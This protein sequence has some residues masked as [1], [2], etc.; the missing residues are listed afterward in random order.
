MNFQKLNINSNN[1]YYEKCIDLLVQNELVENDA[2]NIDS[3]C[4]NKI[5]KNSGEYNFGNYNPQKIF[6]LCLKNN[7][8]QQDYTRQSHKQENENQLLDYEKQLNNLMNI[9]NN[10][11]LRKRVIEKKEIKNKS[12]PRIHTKYAAD[13]LQ[14]KCKNLVLTYALEF[15]NYQIKKIYDG[16]IGNGIYI[17]KLLDINQEQKQKN[18]LDYINKFKYKTI[19]EI[20]STEISK[21]YKSY[22]PNHNEIII[23]RAL[24]EKNENKRKKFIKLFNLTFLDYIHIFLGNVKSIDYEGFQIF[25]DIKGKFNESNEYI[26]KMKEFLIYLGKKT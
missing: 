25:D 4:C 12:S 1:F 6:E 20:F 14:R 26:N 23:K 13:N 22:M 24:S 7:I 19:K 10:L 15:L 18:T 8:T 17:K 16:N 5:S 11:L 9:N 21:R 3:S 2:N